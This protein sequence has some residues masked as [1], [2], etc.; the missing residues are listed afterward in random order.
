MNVGW[1]VF[2]F[3]SLSCCTCLFGPPPPPSHAYTHT[4]ASTL[5]EQSGRQ[6]VDGL[7][8]G[9]KAL[10]YAPTTG[11]VVPT[12]PIGGAFASAEAQAAIEDRLWVVN[13]GIPRTTVVDYRRGLNSRHLTFLLRSSLSFDAV[14][15]S[16]GIHDRIAEAYTRG[17][18]PQLGLLFTEYMQLRQRIDPGALQSVF[19]AGAGFPVIFFCFL[20]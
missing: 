14:V 2:F 12:L 3:S 9:V 8:P 10:N 6:D 19:D 17:D 13:T 16:Y 18:V 11:F 15:K 20:K 4:D 1:L 5:R 7:L